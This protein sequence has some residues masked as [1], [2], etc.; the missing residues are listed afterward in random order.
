MVEVENIIKSIAQGE[1]LYVE[2]KKSEQSLS[3]SVFV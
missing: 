1:G 2:F 3:R